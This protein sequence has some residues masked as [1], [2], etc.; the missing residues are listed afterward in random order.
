MRYLFTQSHV[1]T[2]TL[3]ILANPTF[4]DGIVFATKVGVFAG[5]DENGNQAFQ[6]CEPVKYIAGG[7]PWELT[8][9]TGNLIPL[10]SVK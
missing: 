10:D 7:G 6:A 8:E 5:L 1:N 3:L 9:F 4:K 2:T